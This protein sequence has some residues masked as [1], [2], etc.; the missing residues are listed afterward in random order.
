[1]EVGQ[2]YFKFSLPSDVWAEHAKKLVRGDVIWIPCVS[3]IIQLEGC[4][5]SIMLTD[6]PPALMK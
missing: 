6:W 4:Q 1:M 2:T 3:C 5:R